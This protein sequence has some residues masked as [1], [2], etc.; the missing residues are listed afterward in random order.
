MKTS[1]SIGLCL[2][3]CAG[4]GS[5]LGQTTAGTAC[6]SS[7]KLA[8]VI[9]NLYGP[10]GLVLPNAFHQ[11]HFVSSFQSNF[12]PLGGALATQLTLL[13]LAS[14]ASGF[15]Y[16]FDRTAGV[17]TRSAQSLGPILTERAETLGRGK[18]F[19]SFAY[20]R[21]NFSSVD[22]VS[23]DSLPAVF[24]HTHA[25]NITPEPEYENDV[26]TT[27]NDIN[28]KVNQ[29]TLFGA[30]GL[31][32]RIDLSVA[33]PLMDVSLDVKSNAT[34]RRIAGPNSQFGEAHYFDS[35]DPTGS[36]NKTFTG[37]GSSTGLG[38]VT[39]RL[40]GNVWKNAKAGLAVAADFRAPTGDEKNFLGSGAAG[41][42]P[43][44]AA[45]LHAGRFAPHVNVGY[46]W[47]GDSV[48]AG[49]V[50][51]NV[52]AHLPNQFFYSL[53]TEF[54]A[55]KPLT[56]TFDFLGQ[57]VID[58]TG[59]VRTT[60]TTAASTAHPENSSKTFNN[61]ALSN[62]SFNLNNGSLGFKLNPFSSFVLT[63]N[64]IFKMN[65]SGLRSTVV[66]MFGGS[67]TF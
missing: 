6:A 45:S 10:Q 24:T 46:Q 20:Q 22:G 55:A 63:A 5:A 52:K 33:I 57:R 1:D 48:L 65:D 51:S 64:L 16:T 11:A 7:S 30:V 47:N 59:V 54:S 29:F 37:R 23:L 50:T 4:V 58:A 66:P 27:D 39:F 12:T 13:P 60:F 32:N 61:I 19:L 28:F 8:C 40:K 14:P 36:I 2:L 35:A 62:H 21:F 17:Y 9:P 34:I 3:I 31:T 38:D 26:I 44:V 41:F 56:I 43:F 25:E 42:K 49:D 18:F 67:Y 53:G 15:T